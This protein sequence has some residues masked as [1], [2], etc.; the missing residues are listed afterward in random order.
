MLPEE[1]KK[2]RKKKAVTKA[3]E[4]DLNDDM[5]K[6]KIS[7]KQN[8]I[9]LPSSSP[10]SPL[11]GVPRQCQQIRRLEHGGCVQAV[12]MAYPL[13]QV[14]TGGGGTVKVWDISQVEATT[15]Q[16]VSSFACPAA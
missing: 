8:S 16:P 12:V 3:L 15:N 1:S 4:V 11:S 6:C 5:K 7:S 13:A 2:N 14:Y 9:E 10:E